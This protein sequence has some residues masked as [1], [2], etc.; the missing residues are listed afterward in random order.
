MFPKI[1]HLSDLVPFIERNSQI[2]VKPDERTGQTVVCYMVQDEDTFAGEHLSYERECRGITF[3]SDGNISSRTLHKFFNVGERDDTQPHALSWE[4]VVRIMT[5]RDGSMISAVRHG[6]FFA[7]KTK[8]S[9]TTPEAQCAAAV[10]DA[11]RGGHDWINM[12]LDRG[13]TPTFE[14]TSPRFPI[15]ILYEKDELTLLHVRETVSGRYLHEDELVALNS[16]F[17]IV[18]NEIDKFYDDASRRVVSWEK[19]K[20]AAENETG[21]E[22]WVI[23]FADGEMVKLK[24]KWYCELHHS[25]TFTR[26]RD[27]ARTVLAD[28]SDDLK[29]A[30]AL[31]GRSIE[32]ILEIERKIWATV[33]ETQCKVAEI[34]KAS[35]DKTAKDMALEHKG[36]PLFSLIMTAFRGKEIN[37]LEWYEKNHIDDWSL[38]V[39]A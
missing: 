30:F 33:F 16:P 12:M 36:N 17:P 39:I 37:W 29:G 1:S 21:I 34:I 13:L 23:Q 6:S 38:E 24:T 3:D 8:K 15:V 9:F 14:I 31:V 28:Q 25:V 4:N 27:V 20:T 19:L 26:W 32:P 10:T 35:D 11:T 22:G 2:R 5:K 18:E 7:F